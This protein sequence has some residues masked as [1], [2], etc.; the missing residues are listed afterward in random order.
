MK[1][2]TIQSVAK[3]TIAILEKHNLTMDYTLVSF[4]QVFRKG[5][6]MKQECE[7]RGWKNDEI[8]VSGTGSSSALALAAFEADI[9][10]K[11]G[12]DVVLESVEI[13]EQNDDDDQLPY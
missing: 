2:V 8:H 1:K 3:K 11:L 4:N 12:K 9:L 7:I 5:E 13:S 10:R 6:Q